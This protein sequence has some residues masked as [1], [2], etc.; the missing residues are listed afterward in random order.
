MGFLDN[1]ND[2]GATNRAPAHQK[3][4]EDDEDGKGQC[5]EVGLRVKT[6]NHFLG[7]HN[8]GTEDLPDAPGQRNTQQGT[9]G[10]GAQRE[11]GQFLAQFRFQNKDHH[12]LLSGVPSLR[13]NGE[14]SGRAHHAGVSCDKKNGKKGTSGQ[15]SVLPPIF[16]PEMAINF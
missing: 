11:K 10:A 13:Q 7:I 2:I 14:D 12:Y 15:Q 1:I 9:S 16:P 3:Q 6:Q 8:H 5:K 4:H